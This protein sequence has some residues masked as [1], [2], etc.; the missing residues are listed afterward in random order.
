M[1]AFWRYFDLLVSPGATVV[2]AIFALVMSVV[3]A[4]AAE[5]VSSAA[6]T[7]TVQVVVVDSVEYYVATATATLKNVALAR[8]MAETRAITKIARHIS[9]NSNINRD[10]YGRRVEF[11]RSKPKDGKFMITATV[12]VPVGLNPKK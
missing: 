11:S 8:S 2:F 5:K 6:N 3:S 1:K 7:D 12:Y 10:I 9:G 4:F